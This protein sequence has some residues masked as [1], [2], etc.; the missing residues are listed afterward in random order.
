MIINLP[1]LILILIIMTWFGAFGGFLL[2]KA[3]SYD[4]K[5]EKFQVLLSL[6][7]GVFFYGSAAILNIMA[8]HYLPY[9]IVFPLTAVTYIWTMIISYFLLKEHIS[10]RKLTGVSLIVIGAIILVL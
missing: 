5:T 10:N 7:F 6:I 1:T 8:L 2:K 9:T 3:S 4:F